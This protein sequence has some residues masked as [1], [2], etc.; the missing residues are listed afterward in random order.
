MFR[1]KSSGY[2]NDINL[3]G[4]FYLI[5]EFFLRLNFNPNV[6]LIQ[7]EEPKSRRNSNKSQKSEPSVD[8]NGNK[9]K[10]DAPSES[11]RIKIDDADYDDTVVEHHDSDIE[12]ESASEIDEDELAMPELPIKYLIIDCSPINFIDSVGV[13]T[14]KNV[15][16]FLLFNATQYIFQHQ[17]LF[18]VLFFKLINDYHEIGIKVYLAELNGN[19][20]SFFLLILFYII[21]N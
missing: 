5:F 7:D 20:A 19:L 15:F 18:F 11:I 13:K 8:A 9:R 10:S 21:D 17:Y 1:R 16:D 4:E 3:N 2:D 14:I 12:I 6:T